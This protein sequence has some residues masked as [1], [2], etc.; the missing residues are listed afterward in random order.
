MK[1]VMQNWQSRGCETCLK[2]GKLCSTTWKRVMGMNSPPEEWMSWEFLPGT[3]FRGRVFLPC[4]ST[5][6]NFI[7]ICVCVCVYTCVGVPTKTCL[8]TLVNPCIFL[9]LR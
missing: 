4:A 8:C 1:Q 6:L 5:S 7:E 2:E 3:L 9:K